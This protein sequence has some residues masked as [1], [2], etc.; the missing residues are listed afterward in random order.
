MKAIDQIKQIESKEKYLSGISALVKDTK[1]L[2]DKETPIYVMLA[3]ALGLVVLSL[4]NESTVIP[5]V[6]MLNIGYS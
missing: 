4:T 1:D 6:F 5:F 2:I 3:V